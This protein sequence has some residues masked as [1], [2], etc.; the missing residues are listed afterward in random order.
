MSFRRTWESTPTAAP[1][2]QW[3]PNAYLTDGVHLL[4]TVSAPITGAGQGLVAVE[5]CRT[6]DVVLHAQ[7]ELAALQLRLVRPAPEPQLGG[8]GSQQI[9][10]SGEP[11]LWEWR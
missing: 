5:D 6:L 11:P 2:K 10:H 9:G 1:Q 3:R 7:E 8:S 4:R